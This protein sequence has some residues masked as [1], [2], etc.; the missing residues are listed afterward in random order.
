MRSCRVSWRPWAPDGLHKPMGPT[1]SHG[2]PA[3]AAE[4]PVTS[5]HPW[6]FFSN[7]RPL[8]ASHDSMCGCSNGKAMASLFQLLNACTPQA[9]GLVYLPASHMLWSVEAGDLRGP[10]LPTGGDSSASSEQEAAPS[11]LLVPPSLWLF[12]LSF[13]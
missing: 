6:R 10:G 13:S 9:K 1:L 4:L 8:S 7:F 12:C 5:G 3:L 2:P 11:S